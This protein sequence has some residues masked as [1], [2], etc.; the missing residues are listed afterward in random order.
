[1]I[2]PNCIMTNDKLGTPS[3]R[4][5]ED[6]KVLNT[7]QH[8]LNTYYIMCACGEQKKNTKEQKKYVQLVLLHLR[9]ILELQRRVIS[10][11]HTLSLQGQTTLCDTLHLRCETC[12]N[13]ASLIMQKLENKSCFCV[14]F[15]INILVIMT[16]QLSQKK[17]P[18]YLSLRQESSLPNYLFTFTKGA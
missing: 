11:H 9:T 3:V 4:E 6:S 1:M 18:T 8:V 14:S 17:E 10:G 13:V 12:I 2:T 16:I 7:R 15:I 5:T